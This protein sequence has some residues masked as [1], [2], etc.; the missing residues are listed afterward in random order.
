MVLW[1]QAQDLLWQL[2]LVTGASLA[3]YPILGVEGAGSFPLFVERDHGS[4][5]ITYYEVVTRYFAMKL[6]TPKNIGSFV[7][8]DNI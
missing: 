8:F 5:F 1:S 2:L 6:G 7:H 4:C 3:T